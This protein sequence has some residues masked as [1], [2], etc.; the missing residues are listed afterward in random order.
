MVGITTAATIWV[1]AA[2]GM[3]A[4]GGGYT[5]AIAGTLMSV[6][7]LRLPA[8]FSYRATRGAWTSHHPTSV[9]HRTASGRQAPVGGS[10][11]IAV[12]SAR[13]GGIVGLGV[14]LD[15]QAV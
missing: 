4:G 3:L 8:R 7:V 9:T 10:G 5:L 15:V 13:G 2:V 1:A 11:R 12:A 6:L 14:E